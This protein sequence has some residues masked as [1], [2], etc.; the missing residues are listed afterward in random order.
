MIVDC[1]FVLKKRIGRIKDKIKLK[2]ID[3]IQNIRS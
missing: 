3:E 2:S 1:P